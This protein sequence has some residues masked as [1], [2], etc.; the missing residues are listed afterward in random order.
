MNRTTLGQ[1]LEQRA[2]YVRKIQSGEEI[3]EAEKVVF[4]RALA[5]LSH[6][7]A[8]KDNYE[9]RKLWSS[10]RYSRADECFNRDATTVAIEH[11][12]N[13]DDVVG[14]ATLDDTNASNGPSDAALAYID[15]TSRYLDTCFSYVG[16]Q[17]GLRGGRLRGCGRLDGQLT[18]FAK[19]T[20]EGIVDDQAPR[21][22]FPEDR[23][24]IPQ[25]TEGLSEEQ[26]AAMIKIMD[27]DSYYVEVMYKYLHWYLEKWPVPG[28]QHWYR[29]RYMYRYLYIEI[30]GIFSTFFPPFFFSTFWA[31]FSSLEKFPH[32]AFHSHR[33]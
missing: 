9:L 15:T 19:R 11:G 22:P 28:T 7:S 1:I 17:C 14:L 27:V 25:L 33:F 32:P 8:L 24:P 5:A 2:A 20:A 18:E 12:V 30:W 23:L 26:K 16:G 21:Y 31:H 6:L 29:N 10:Y 3:N 13:L 4:G